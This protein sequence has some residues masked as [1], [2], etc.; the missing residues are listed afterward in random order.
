VSLFATGSIE[1]NGNPN[2]QDY[3]AQTLP[4]YATQVAGTPSDENIGAL[5][6]ASTTAIP[7]W[8]NGGTPLPAV[9]VPVQNVMLMAGLD[10]G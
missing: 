8:M 7:P 3:R 2:I 6:D 5:N 4:K 9:P 1:I 10:G